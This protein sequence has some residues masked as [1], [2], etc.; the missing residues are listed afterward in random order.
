[1]STT[2]TITQESEPKTT[3]DRPS[4]GGTNAMRLDG[5]DPKWGDFRDDL[6]QDGYAVVKGAVP[7]ER[8]LKYADDMYS[9]LE[10]L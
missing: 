6:A 2:T 5:L 4:L 9:Y 7:R 10:G 3:L 8:A 1:M